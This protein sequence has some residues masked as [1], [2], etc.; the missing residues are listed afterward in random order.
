MFLG[1]AQLSQRAFFM[2]R[3][4]LH[5][6]AN[7]ENARKF[8]CSEVQRINSRVRRSL[9]FSRKSSIKAF[10]APVEEERQ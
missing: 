5:Q 6:P 1:H 4:K 9:T 2:G 7:R 3:Q 10:G 8:S